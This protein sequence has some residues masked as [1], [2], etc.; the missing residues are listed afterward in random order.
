[1]QSYEAPGAA[2]ESAR[3]SSKPSGKPKRSVGFQVRE[4]VRIDADGPR[5]NIVL[6]VFQYAEAFRT[7][8]ERIACEARSGAPPLRV[9]AVDFASTE[10]DVA[11]T[12]A[13]SGLDF[14]V[15][16]R[17]QPF[18]RVEAIEHG[19]AA[20]P[21]GEIVFVSDLHVRWPAR[22]FSRIARFV[23][24][25]RTVYCPLIRH[26]LTGQ[27]RRDWCGLAAFAVDDVRSA[28]LGTNPGFWDPVDRWSYGKEDEILLT[29]LMDEDLQ[30]IRTDEGWLHLSH[31]RTGSGWYAGK[32]NGSYEWS[33]ES[34]WI[35]H[36]KRFEAF[37][38]RVCAI[39]ALSGVAN[40]A[41]RAVQDA[42]RQAKPFLRDGAVMEVSDVLADGAG[43]WSAEVRGTEADGT[44]ALWGV[45]GETGE[46]AC[47]SAW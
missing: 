41:R 19:V 47:D 42:I 23:R 37:T 6:P 36:D 46:D 44:R 45:W 5:I 43:R 29:R 26:D 7:L 13:A 2:L 35:S 12:L 17:P 3:N 21:A 31:Q 25:S 8:V 32:G 1:M 30:T 4:A 33:A 39:P 11:A 20:A 28:G 24:P 10:L 9:I 18:S 16:R 15:V 34:G 38:E 14:E 27:I 40:P 22:V